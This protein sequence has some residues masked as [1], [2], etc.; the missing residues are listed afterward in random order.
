MLH[1]SEQ[2]AICLS[3]IRQHLMEAS[4]LTHRDISFARPYRGL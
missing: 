1:G 2:H 4:P 3:Q